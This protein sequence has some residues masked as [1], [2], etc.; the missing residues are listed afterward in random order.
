MRSYT[1]NYELQASNILGIIDV[2][3]IIP[4]KKLSSAET[5]TIVSKNY[6]ALPTTNK[7]SKSFEQSCQFQILYQQ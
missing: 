5:Q 2:M 4:Q 1:V 6:E 7:I 3:S